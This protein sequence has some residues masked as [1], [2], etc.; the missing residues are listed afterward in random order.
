MARNI[1]K[2]GLEQKIEKVEKAISRNRE[3]Y[4]RLT[5]ELEELHKKQKA[6]QSE[7]LLKAIAESTR[8][9]EEIL[10]FI[11]GKAEEENDA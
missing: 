8:S 7:E 5:A 4:D 9:Y 6:I 10:R 2:E 3:Q 11:Q 1:S